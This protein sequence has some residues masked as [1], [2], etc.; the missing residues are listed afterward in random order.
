LLTA[1]GCAS[2][3]SAE[4]E[5]AEATETAAQEAGEEVESKASAIERS[6]PPLEEPTFADE[7]PEVEKIGEKEDVQ[8]FRVGEMKVIYKPTPANSVV[9]TKLYIDGGVANLTE[10]TSGI[11][12][13]ALRTAVDGGSESTPRDEFNA[14]LDSMG[15]S[16]GYF[17]SRDY[18]GYTLRSIVK[19]FDETWSLFE[20]AILQPAIPEAEVETQRRKQIAEIQ[21]I[22]ENPNQLVGHLSRELIAAGHPY[23]FLHVGTEANVRAFSPENLKA[24]HHSLLDPE[25]M[26]LVFV[27]DVPVDEVLGKVKSK[28][29]RLEGDDEDWA[30]PDLPAFDVQKA[31]LEGA[32]KS[33]PTNYI[34]GQFAAPAP[35]DEDYAATRLALSYLSDRLFEEIRT[36]RNLSYA[37]ASGLGQNRTNTGYIYVSAKQPNKTMKVMLDEIEQ[38]RETTLGTKQLKRTRNVFVTEYYMD[39][40][41]NAGQASALAR[42]ELLWG[43]W[44]EH[45]TFLD[46]IRRVTPKDVRRAARTYLQ[47]YQFGVVGHPDRIDRELFLGRSD[48]SE[49]AAK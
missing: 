31:R 41:T 16:V 28:L 4:T 46:R 34:L 32:K 20:Q 27:G 13:L 1:A 49:R 42:A 45:L 12:K 40:E 25:R 44:R 38:L 37:V 10:G 43:D 14:Q 11:E 22:S 30:Q 39:L 24:Y 9:S 19:H 3:Q 48:G 18:S 23:R 15:S 8:A 36:K 29:A 6:I 35:G 47:H 5:T 17:T 2:S 33:I 21:K 7:A 26:T